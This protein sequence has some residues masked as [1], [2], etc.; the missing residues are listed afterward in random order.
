MKE[1]IKKTI[2]ETSREKPELINSDQAEIGPAQQMQLDAYTDN[3]TLVIYSE[4]SQPAIL[5]S[6]QSEKEPIMSVA[7]TAFIVHKKL[8]SSLA[9]EGEK[10]TEITMALGAAHVVSE[11]VVLAEAAGLYTLSPEERL[12]A[13]KQAVMKYMEAGLKDGSIDPVELQ[14]SIE[15]LMTREQR[16][17]GMQQME[18][19]SL[20]KTAPPSNMFKKPQ[21]QPQSQG[22]LRR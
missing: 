9:A 17:Y 7:V 4:E 14:K 20:S 18:Q 13:Y 10:M 15:P 16:D 5:Q 22:I 19:H 12:E 3:A 6:L 2:P 11:L 1:E 21:E 8:E